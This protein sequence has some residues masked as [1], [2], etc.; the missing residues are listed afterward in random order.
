MIQLHKIIN[1]DVDIDKNIFLDFQSSTTRGHD[2]KLRKKKATKLT[3]IN[4]F[5]NKVVNDWN[6]LPP[7]VVTAATTNAFK[8]AIDKYWED[9]MYDTPF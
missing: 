4:V 6:S 9:K 5:S 1:N 7:N 3:R 2:C 8:N